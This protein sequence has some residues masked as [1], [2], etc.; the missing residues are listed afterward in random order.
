MG[1]T[2]VAKAFTENWFANITLDIN[3]LVFVGVF[4]TELNTGI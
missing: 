4:L 3:F 2:S 1:G